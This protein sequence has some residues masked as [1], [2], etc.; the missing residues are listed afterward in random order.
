[1]HFRVL[2]RVDGVLSRHVEFFRHPLVTAWLCL[3]FLP[4]LGHT[5]TPSSLFQLLTTHELLDF[6]V[7]LGGSQG[8]GPNVQGLRN[9]RGTGTGLR[10]VSPA[11]V[12]STTPN[13]PRPVHLSEH[14]L[15]NR[16]CAHLWS[17]NVKRKGEHMA[18][19]GVDTC[20]P[21]GFKSSV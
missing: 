18:D 15:E 1:M 20:L 8:L 14:Q 11:L 10:K 7:L 5:V 13:G 2:E 4:P 21:A 9:K 19:G 12:K 3:I 16:D 17:H 6:G